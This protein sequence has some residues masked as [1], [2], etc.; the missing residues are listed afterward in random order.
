[1][2]PA[3]PS[4]LWVLPRPLGLLVVAAL[5]LGARAFGPGSE[6]APAAPAPVATPPDRPAREAAN[7]QLFRQSIEQFM[8]RH[9]PSVVDRYFA[10]NYVQ[11][12][13]EVA[14][15][16]TAQ[17]ISQADNTRRFF[18]G[19]FAAV[20]DFHVTID[21]LYAE[22]DK[23]FA[24]VTWTGTHRGPLFGVPATGRAFTSRTAEIMRVEHG[25]FAEHWDVVDQ[26]HLLTVLGRRPARPKE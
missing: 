2:K 26:T 5:A 7:K 3:F 25:R 13:A 24:F 11:H 22:D 4:P 6:V 21:H 16:A 9:A 15:L 8:N 17:G 18:A 14:R 10:P 20:P 19:F 23:V 12:N 1:M